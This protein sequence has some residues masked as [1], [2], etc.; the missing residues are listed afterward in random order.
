MGDGDKDKPSRLEASI[1]QLENKLWKA[2]RDG[3][4]K[5]LQKFIDDYKDHDKFQ[6]VLNNND[7]DYDEDGGH[8]VI[9]CVKEGREK[10]ST[11]GGRDHGA[12]MSLLVKNGADV[13]RTD[14][15]HKTALSWAVTFKYNSYAS[16]L[17]HLGADVSIYDQDG[18][19]PLHIAVYRGYKDIVASFLDSDPK[20]CKHP[21]PLS[22]AHYFVH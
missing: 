9:Y 11:F 10:G 15:A 20:V 8:V 21:C 2:V 12:C 22:N 7:P 16:R 14:M 19:S 4:V 3:K 17:L 18:N 13:N 6:H 1:P 5:N